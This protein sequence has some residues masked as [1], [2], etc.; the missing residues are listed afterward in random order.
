MAQSGD[1]VEQKDAAQGLSED[2]RRHLGFLCHDL[3][4]FTSNRGAADRLNAS[5]HP[6]FIGPPYLTEQ[7]AT[8]AL[9]STLQA[10]RNA[11]CRRDAH[12]PNSELDTGV[13]AA[14]SITLSAFLEQRTAEVIAAREAKRSGEGGK[15]RDFV[16]CT[17]HDLA[18]ILVEACGFPKEYFETRAFKDAY[19]RWETMLRKAKKKGKAKA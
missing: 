5:V 18:P 19:K 15:A 8:T 1:T 13:G 16:L 10:L 9:S 2:I 17:S 11:D 14:G 6:H 3:R 7:D 12:V 4:T